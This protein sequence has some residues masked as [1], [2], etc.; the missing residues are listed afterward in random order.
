MKNLFVIISLVG[1]LQGV[2]A[3][4]TGF[5]EDISIPNDHFRGIIR[6]NNIAYYENDRHEPFFAY[7]PSFVHS[8]PA[9]NHTYYCVPIDNNWIVRDFRV[10]NGV[11]YFCG[12]DTWSNTALL[13]HFNISNLVSGSGNVSFYRDVNLTGHLGCLNRIA[14]KTDKTTVSVMAIGNERCELRPE[15]TGSDRGLYIDDYNAM[16][17]CIFT[18]NA[19]N[20]VFWDVVSTESCF[21]VTG[22][23]GYCTNLLTMRQVPFGTS[24]SAFSTFFGNRNTYSCAHNFNGGVRSAALGG[25]TIAVAVHYTYDTSIYSST[26]K[27]FG[28]QMSTIYVPSAQMLKNQWSTRVGSEDVVFSTPRDMIYLRGSTD[29]M[30]IDTTPYIESGVL[31]TDPYPTAGYVPQYYFYDVSFQYDSNEGVILTPP[32]CIEKPYYAL[33]ALS[34]SKCV[35][36]AGAKWLVLDFNTTPLPYHANNCV[37]SYTIDMYPCPSIVPALDWVE[38]DEQY[39]MSF[40]I[41]AIPVEPA[42][43]TH[44]D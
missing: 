29:L 10:L 13:G 34:P 9:T 5:Y 24:V 43:Y 4:T 2:A 33:E 12:I 25:D 35:A 44:C 28:I 3:Q 38:M 20:E 39:N 21:A 14:V 8:V 15:Q 16:T 26:Y 27:R 31:R 37:G 40:E 19:N 1:C 23:Q 6:D 32:Q 18:P 30:I 36:S 41:M 11:V 22:T 42:S 7:I 17:G